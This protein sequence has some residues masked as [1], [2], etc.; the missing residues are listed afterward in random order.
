LLALTSFIYLYL[1]GLHGSIAI[2]EM[3]AWSLVAVQLGRTL[4]Y[5][6]PLWF[7]MWQPVAALVGVV[8]LSLLINPPGRTFLEQVG[9]F[10]CFILMYFFAWIFDDLWNEQFEGRLKRAWTI[11]FL[12]A[13]SYGVFQCLTGIDLV[14]PGSNVL[15]R[16][17]GGAIWRSTGFF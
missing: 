10:R 2:M 7:P 16:T 15:E 14:R 12:V 5:R 1:I 6:K 9:F 13:G 8:T 4:Y 17:G 11:A 3:A